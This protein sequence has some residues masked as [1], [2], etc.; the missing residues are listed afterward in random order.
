LK[1]VAAFHAGLGAAG[2]LAQPG[3][4]K[5]KVLVQNGADDPF[6]KPESVEAFRKEMDAAKVNYRYISYPGAVH[7]FTNPEAT[8]FFAGVLK[9]SPVS[10]RGAA[11]RKFKREDCRSGRG[12]SVNLGWRSWLLARS[13]DGTQGCADG[14]PSPL[15]TIDDRFRPGRNRGRH[16]L[17]PSALQRGVGI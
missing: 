5:A 13:G 7:A 1:G 6:V 14:G 4:V 2:A 15:E 10:V 3:E 17:E 8:S 9:S 16:H 12:C 11:D